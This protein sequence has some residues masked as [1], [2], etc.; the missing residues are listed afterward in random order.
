MPKVKWI[1]LCQR[2]GLGWLLRMTDDRQTDIGNSAIAGRD[3][4][5][6]IDGVGYIPMFQIH[7]TLRAGRWIS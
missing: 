2:D 7:A 1:I 4:K 3:P 6:G 5:G